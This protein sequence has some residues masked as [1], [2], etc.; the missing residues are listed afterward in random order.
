MYCTS[1]KFDPGNP[2]TFHTNFRDVAR[3]GQGT[4][5]TGDVSYYVKT[6]RDGSYGDGSYGY[7]NGVV[8]E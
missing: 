7:Q 2:G 3:G 4:F 6:Y 8:N 5:R 1:L